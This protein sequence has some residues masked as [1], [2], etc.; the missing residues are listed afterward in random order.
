M[1][2]NTQ[3]NNLIYS[4]LGLFLVFLL[5]FVLYFIA[6]NNY[7]IPSPLIV[8][9][10]SF[11]NLLNLNFYSHLLN[12]LLRVTV[13]IAISFLLG[14]TLAVFS[15]LNIRFEGVILPFISII[16]SLPVLAILLIILVCLPRGVAPIVVCTLSVLPIVYTQTLNY[17]NSIDSKQKEVLKIY[18]VPL[19]TQIFSVYLKGYT[20][21]F[22][23]EI[24]ALFS[25][26]LKLVV[27]A[28][29]LANVYNS[30]GGDISNASIYSNVVEL[31]SL[32]LL[33]CL[34]GIIVEKIGSFVCYNM[35]K[36]Y[37]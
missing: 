12:T 3:K 28:E 36:K 31:F 14:V 4:I 24:T 35:E 20:P 9:K 18:K 26:S 37:K 16:R 15:H 25:F 23:K 27:S 32:T 7:L 30:L 11:L 19:K 13:A 21:L 5:W 34:I 1:M 33:I 2:K 10:E 8:L 29:I 17:L 6:S 22:I